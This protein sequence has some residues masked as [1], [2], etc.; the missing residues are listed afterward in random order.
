M[1]STGARGPF[2]LP[3]W[4]AGSSDGEDG[5]LWR[6][7]RAQDAGP[8]GLPSRPSRDRGEFAGQRPR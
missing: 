2:R 5:H 4:R 6:R 7:V 1:I 8:T 3:G